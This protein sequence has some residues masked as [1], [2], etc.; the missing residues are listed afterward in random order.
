LTNLPW[1]VD[2]EH[3]RTTLQCPAVH[4]LNDLEAI[5]YAVPA[6]E[7]S[8]LHTLN[9]GEKITGGHIAI[10]APGTG[11]GEALLLWNGSE[12]RPYPSEGGHASF[13]PTNETELELLRYLW[14]HF[15]HVSYERVCSG[16]GIPNIYAFLKDSG[17][18][19]ESPHIAEKLATA[20]DPTPVIVN[21][22]LSHEAPCP[23]A[24]K[25]LKLFISILGAEAS[26][27]ALKILA[28]G[29]VY[30]GGGIPPRI[31]SALDGGTFMQAFQRKG[32]FTTMLQRVPVH[33]IL[34][35]KAAL[36]GAARRGLMDIM[37]EV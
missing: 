2:E 14:Q 16:I 27:L 33:I 31:L 1:L 5:A 18:A 4:L 11:L 6:L 23:L 7:S 35:S 13:A 21:A 24:E 28:T 36:L 29:G 8:H 17:Y 34:N 9:A 26:N 22:A 30:L 32:R 12:Y 15:T 25:T 20:S 19:E 10:I 3:L 37:A